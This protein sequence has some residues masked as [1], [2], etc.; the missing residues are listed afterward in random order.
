M[1][2]AIEL[3]S[4]F[5]GLFVLS[6]GF[7]LNALITAV[8]L[9]GHPLGAF[10]FPQVNVTDSVVDFLTSGSG[11]SACCFFELRSVALIAFFLKF[12]FVFALLLVFGLLCIELTSEIFASRSKGVLNA[13]KLVGANAAVLIIELS[14]FLLNDGP[15]F[16]SFPRKGFG[17][18]FPNVVDSPAV[19]R[20]SAFHFPVMLGVPRANLFFVS[21]SQLLGLG[22]VLF[23]QLL[24]TSGVVRV[25]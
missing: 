22:L 23:L 9:V 25:I 16:F 12:L 21:L 3:V 6:V 20:V 24:H 15:L 17:R 10:F 8:V 4:Q 13:F 5:P 1:V 11:S 2:V 18:V 14:V 19:L 7:H